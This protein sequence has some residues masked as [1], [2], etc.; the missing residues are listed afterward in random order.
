MC[1][2]PEGLRNR[3]PDGAH[4][5]NE[6]LRTVHDDSEDSP[7]HAQWMIRNTN[8]QST[9]AEKFDLRTGAPDELRRREIR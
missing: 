3:S 9:D 7:S 2:H 4:I 8:Y 5:T 1:I 6:Y